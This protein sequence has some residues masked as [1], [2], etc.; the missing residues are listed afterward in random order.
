MILKSNEVDALAGTLSSEGI[1]QKAALDKFFS[2]E[3]ISNLL[4]E[5]AETLIREKNVRE[6]A[7]MGGVLFMLAGRYKSLL[8]LLNRLLAPPE[9][10]DENKRFWYEQTKQFHAMYLNKRCHVLEMLEKNG[11]MD[12]VTTSRL[13]MELYG[14]FECL[15]LNRFDD[16]LN[17]VDKHDF[18]PLNPQDVSIKEMRFRKMDALLQESLPS[19][20]Q[21]AIQSIYQQYCHAKRNASQAR[22]LELKARA[23]A[24][25]TFAG[26]IP[27]VDPSK[28]DSMSRLEAQM[29]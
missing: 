4:N 14:F 17:I 16:A 1:R 5:A 27:K 26:M 15:A 2:P 24:L 22:S 11:D 18:L 13:L 7:M 10:G 28:I 6:K 25:I 9:I 29:L 23:R 3:E 19:V 21:G 12:V 8:K 20:L